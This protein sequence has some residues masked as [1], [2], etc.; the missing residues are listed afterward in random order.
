MLPLVPTPPPPTPLPDISVVQAGLHV[1]A[2]AATEPTEQP[3][4]KKGGGFLLTAGFLLLIALFVAIFVIEPSK[5][6]TS[7]ANRSPVVAPRSIPTIDSSL[8]DDG[9]AAELLQEIRH[10][11][12]RQSEIHRELRDKLMNKGDSWE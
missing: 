4:E 2:A 12:R 5:E 3:D 7:P 11:F 8:P 1:M 6:T 10:R 9:S